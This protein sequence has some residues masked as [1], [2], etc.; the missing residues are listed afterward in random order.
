MKLEV[1]QEWLRMGSLALELSRLDGNTFIK[2]SNKELAGFRGVAQNEKIRLE[3]L[4]A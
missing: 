1:S 2:R 4:K 3:A